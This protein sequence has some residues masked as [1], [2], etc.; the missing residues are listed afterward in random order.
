M[1]ALDKVTAIGAVDGVAACH[2]AVGAVGRGA[3]VRGA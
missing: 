2:R 3:E 1:G